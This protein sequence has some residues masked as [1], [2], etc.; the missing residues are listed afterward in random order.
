MMK[1]LTNVCRWI[2]SV[3]LLFFCFASLVRA[4]YSIGTDDVLQIRVYG[5][6][7]LTTSVRVSENGRIVFPMVGEVDVAGETE[8]GVARK[9]AQL[10]TKGGFV[11]NASVSVNVMEYRNQQ[12]SVLG[13]VKSPGVYIL[14]SKNTL[15][16]VIAM[17]G[18]INEF[19]DDRV[20]ITRQVNGKTVKQEVDLHAIL[21]SHTQSPEV[22]IER[23]DVIYVPKA[24]VFYIS[25]EVQRSGSFRLER[26]MTVSQAIA[27]G[28]GLT[29]RGTLRGIEIHRRDAGGIV[30]TIDAELS[31]KVLQDD[32]IVIDER[33][34]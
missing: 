30:K 21:E 1:M 25:G 27:V 12:I 16:D 33:L 8:L 22:F 18:G 15:I 34:F 20:V 5:Y 24:V 7:D 6:D 10:L 29:L 31:D 23:G 4:D 26:D 19:G 17:A 28:G 14:K 3:L 32:V 13:Q 11:P 2:F 9:I